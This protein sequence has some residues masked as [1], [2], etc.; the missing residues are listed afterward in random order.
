MECKEIARLQ[1]ELSDK[2]KQSRTKM[3]KL[4]VRT[5]VDGSGSPD[6]AGIPPWGRPEGHE[7]CL[8]AFEGLLHG[9]GMNLPIEAPEDRKEPMTCG[10]G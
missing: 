10:F 2:S 1:R 8:Q 6:T 9:R 7:S 5:Q 4:C 3:G